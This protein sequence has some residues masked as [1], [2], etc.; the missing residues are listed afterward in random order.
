LS[1]FDFELFFTLFLVCRFLCLLLMLQFF[2]LLD[3]ILELFLAFLVL[4]LCFIGSLIRTS[5]FVS[6]IVNGLIKEEIKKP[7]S[8][9]LSLSVMS[10]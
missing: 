1:F 4:Q 3:D 6:F 2:P 5:N 7:S 8:Q 10:H 9:F